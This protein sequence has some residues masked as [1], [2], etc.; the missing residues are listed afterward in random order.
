M[1]KRRY[2]ITDRT[3]VHALAQA[4]LDGIELIQIREKHLTASQLAVHV[5]AV[6]RLPN[7]H[8]AKILVN[9]RADVAMACGAHGVHLRSNSISPRTLRQMTPEGFLI[10][11]SCHS[12][13]D[14]EAA[15]GADF[16]VLAP[17]FETPGKPAPLGLRCL[18]Q[19][20]HSTSTPVFAL[21]GITTDRVA[22]CLRLGAAGVAG[23]RLFQ[24]PREAF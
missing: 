7:P 11:S 3:P 13:R 24:S 23:I 21:G 10:A 6:L 4:L 20:V 15:E 12:I 18:A 1:L 2:L 16:V 8:G 17:I 9:D 5:K 19:A 22:V 14:I